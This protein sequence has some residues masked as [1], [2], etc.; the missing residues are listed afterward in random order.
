MD[1][2]ILLLS[3]CLTLEYIELSQFGSIPIYIGFKTIYLRL[4][5]FKSGD[6]VY[7]EVS[8]LSNWAT[9]DVYSIS[10]RQSNYL[11]DSEFSSYSFSDMEPITSSKSNEIKTRYYTIKLT[12]NYQYLLFKFSAD[13][14]TYTIK[15][16]KTSG[17]SDTSDKGIIT[18]IIIIIVLIIAVILIIRWCRRRAKESY[19]PTRMDTPLVQP[20][21]QPKYTQPGY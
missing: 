10:Y 3:F 19:T 4:D 13:D 16:S 18:P 11:S 14:H 20:Q 17:I 15:H 2:L 8:Y 21:S 9:L 7:I 6:N 5:G 12:G 1:L